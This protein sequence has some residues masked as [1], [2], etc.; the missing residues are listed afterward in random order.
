MFQRQN[1]CVNKPA[2]KDNMPHVE[3]CGIHTVNEE[4]KQQKVYI[5][6]AK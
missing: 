5:K 3:E 6:G 2:K 1:D 4:K